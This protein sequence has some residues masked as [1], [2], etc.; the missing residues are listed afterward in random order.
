[1][2]SKGSPQTTVLPVVMKNKNCELRTLA[3]VIKINLD[4]AKKRAVS[5]TYVDSR[6][7]EFEQPAELVLLTSY[8]FNNVRLMLQSGIGK[9]YD[10]VANTG[11]VGRNYAYQTPSGVTLFFEDKVFNQFMAAGGLGM[12]ID[13]FNGA[14][15]DHSG[16]GV[17]GGGFFQA[18][19]SGSRPREVRPVPA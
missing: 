3:N 2:G 5:V 16:L 19:P 18:A 1:M 11:V 8:V 10:P 6:G 15:F 17:I 7:R 12:V 14:N 13:E 9:P 4:S